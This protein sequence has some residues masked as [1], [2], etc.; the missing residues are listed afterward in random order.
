MTT[1][2]YCSISAVRKSRGTTSSSSDPS[3]PSVSLLSSSNSISRK[4]MSGRF[5][6]SVLS[7]CSDVWRKLSLKML[8]SMRQCKGSLLEGVI[9]LPSIE[10]EVFL[11]K[12]S[13]D[14]SKQ[15]L[16]WRGRPLT[17]F[18]FQSS[19]SRLPRVTRSLL[20]LIRL[21]KVLLSS[22]FSGSDF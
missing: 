17:M 8:K 18:F 13:F 7:S 15:S 16:F 14:T 20:M 4:F 5:S 11:V 22:C 19:P 10:T 1:L 6:L 2:F 9:S 3:S 21:S 12:S